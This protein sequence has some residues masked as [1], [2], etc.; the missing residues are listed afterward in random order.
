MKK[1]RKKIKKRTLVIQEELKKFFPP[2]DHMGVTV[3][4]RWEQVKP[5][6]SIKSPKKAVN[7]RPF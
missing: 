6:T 1:R 3:P 4:T 5:T 7:F 2:A